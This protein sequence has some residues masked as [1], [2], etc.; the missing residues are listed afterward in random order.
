MLR[1]LRMKRG[2]PGVMGVILKVSTGLMANRRR[3]SMNSGPALKP[4]GQPSEQPAFA[5]RL[6]L[7][8]FRGAH[9]IANERPLFCRHCDADLASE[10]QCAWDN[11]A[12]VQELSALIQMR[13]GA[14]VE[15]T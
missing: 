1:M 14:I 13:R 11:H 5:T 10:Y 7:G 9:V 15:R 6:A 4:N 3:L 12:P 2:F 8:V